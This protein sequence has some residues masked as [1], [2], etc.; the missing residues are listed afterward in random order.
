MRKEN[1]N[2]FYVEKQEQNGMSQC[3]ICK[4]ENEVI[5]RGKK[6]K[7][8][9]IDFIWLKRGNGEAKKCKVNRL[10]VKLENRLNYSFSIRREVAFTS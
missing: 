7:L 10:H 6:L 3:N 4:R 1:V 9:Y 5:K 2:F 8:H